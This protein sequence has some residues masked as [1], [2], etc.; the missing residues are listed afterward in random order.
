V[1]LA[2]C[3]AELG[4]GSGR[5]GLMLLRLNHLSTHA[6]RS[7]V[8]SLCDLIQS[9]THQVGGLLRLDHLGAH[10]LDHALQL[11]HLRAENGNKFVKEMQRWSA[12]I[13]WEQSAILWCAVITPSGWNRQ[14]HGFVSW[15]GTAATHQRPCSETQ[16]YTRRAAAELTAAAA[17]WRAARS[18]S[19]ACRA[20]PRSTCIGVQDREGENH[21]STERCGMLVHNDTAC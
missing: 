8:A 21:I 4:A 9:I 7:K 11:G 18:A 19:A 12:Q 16:G 14:H 6:A 20:L 3:S 10:A 2:S 17:S 15:H 13:L 5:V 1:L